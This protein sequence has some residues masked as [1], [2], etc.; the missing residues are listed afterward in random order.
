MSPLSSDWLFE[1]DGA[2]NIDSH[3]GLR[4]RQRRLFLR[5]TR[6]EVARALGCAATQIEKFENGLTQIDAPTL[7]SMAERLGV[8]VMDFFHGAPAPEKL[9]GAASLGRIPSTVTS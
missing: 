8:E 4:I 2:V 1:G 6:T 3:I 9:S 7:F 5:L